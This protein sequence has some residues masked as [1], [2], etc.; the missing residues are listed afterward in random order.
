MTF[1]LATPPNMQ[2]FGSDD[3]SSR[4]HAPQ[5]HKRL[6]NSEI[7]ME[8]RESEQWKELVDSVDTFLFD[9]DGRY[10]Q[11]FFVKFSENTLG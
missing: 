9:C 4:D 11:I 8:L 6:D 1:L 7:I 5:G 10:T 2:L 3:P